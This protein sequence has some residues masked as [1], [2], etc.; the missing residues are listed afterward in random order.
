MTAQRLT[1]KWTSAEVVEA[2]R[3][4][5]QGF[6]FREIGHRLGLVPSQVEAKLNYIESDNGPRHFE[7]PQRIEPSPEALADRDMRI[8]AE[9]RRSITGILCGDPVPG[10]SAHDLW[11]KRQT[12]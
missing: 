7:L 3:L 8:A 5:K 12:A 4:K 9:P 11:L 2:K 10:F 6:S 1:H